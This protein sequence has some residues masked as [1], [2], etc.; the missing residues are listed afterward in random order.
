MIEGISG[1]YAK[2][3]TTCCHW[4]RHMAATVRNL[5]PH[6][7]DQRRR[8]PLQPDRHYRPG[9]RVWG[10]RELLAVLPR[11]QGGRVANQAQDG[12]PEL[13]P[14]LHGLH[15]VGEAAQAA[16]GGDQDIIHTAVLQFVENLEPEFSAF[17][18]LDPQPQHFLVPVGTTGENV[19]ANKRNDEQFS[20]EEVMRAWAI[21]RAWNRTQPFARHNPSSD[22]MHDKPFSEGT[23]ICEHPARVAAC[24]AY[25][26][27][28]AIYQ[29]PRQPRY[30][31]AP[32]A[33]FDLGQPF[34]LRA[35]ACRSSGGDSY[36]QA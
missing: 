2:K 5:V 13:R 18:L 35:N 7:P 4:L 10:R 24:V 8:A 25:G 20:K 6:G 16:D 34:S 1:G 26:N 14:W 19:R 3:G 28:L 36:H 15:G 23:T 33:Q 21:P 30:S 22:G 17:S 9:R 29:V 27:A 31:D 11:C 32:T 12:C